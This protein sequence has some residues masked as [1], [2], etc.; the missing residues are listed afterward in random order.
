M[1]IMRFE[2]SMSQLSFPN[3]REQRQIQWEELIVLSAYAMTSI[4]VA[5]LSLSGS[6]GHT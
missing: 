5:V 4:N 3:Y 2:I 1:I 6:E